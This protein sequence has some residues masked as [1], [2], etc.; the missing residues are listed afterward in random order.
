MQNAGQ[1]T[2]VLLGALIASMAAGC[3]RSQPTG[4]S[5]ASDQT[6]TSTTPVAPADTSYGS[7]GSGSSYQEPSNDN[8]ITLAQAETQYQ[9]AIQRCDSMPS[10]Q[11]DSCEDAA[12]QA[13]EEQKA[14][15]TDQSTDQQMPP[16]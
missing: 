10:D 14:D 2:A 16:K 8:T 11:Q 9:D 7:T 5:P 13:F 15:A 1:V 3:Q 12:R 4:Q 6:A